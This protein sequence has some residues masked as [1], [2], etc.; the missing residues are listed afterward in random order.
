MINKSEIEKLIPHGHQ[1][2]LLDKVLESD[3]QHIV[4]STE[5]HLRDDNPLIEGGQLEA[6]AL[7]E[8]G[9]QAAAIHA[10]LIHSGMG[11]QKPA[12]LGAIKTLKLGLINLG[13][14]TSALIVEA[15]CELSNPNGAIYSINVKSADKTVI[16]GRIILI[17]PDQVYFT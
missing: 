2:C 16:S 10:A 15:C 7:V 17:Q 5:S 13:N 3:E 12:Y 9:A 4:C 6:V 14:I 11:E 1:M 8:Y